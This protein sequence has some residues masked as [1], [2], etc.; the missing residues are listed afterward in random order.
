[1]FRKVI[2]NVY[3]RQHALNMKLPERESDMRVP[4]IVF[5]MIEEVVNVARFGWGATTF[6]G[7]AEVVFQ[8]QI[9]LM[10]GAVENCFSGI[11]GNLMYALG[12]GT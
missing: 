2:L 3:V 12:S 9:V 10:H 8:A 1:M 7:T 11:E 4:S 6:R 5:K